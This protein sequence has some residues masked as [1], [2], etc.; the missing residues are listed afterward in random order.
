MNDPAILEAV[1]NLQ[2]RNERTIRAMADVQNIVNEV[3][4]MQ[5]MFHEHIMKCHMQMTS[6]RALD[7]L[8][9]SLI[10]RMLD[11]TFE[12]LAQGK[13]FVMNYHHESMCYH[14]IGLA[15]KSFIGLFRKSHVKDLEFYL[16][17]RNSSGQQEC[18][19]YCW[20]RLIS[21]IPSDIATAPNTLLETQSLAD[22]L[23]ERKVRRDPRHG[24]ILPI[25]C[26]PAKQNP[27]NDAWD[28]WTL[29]IEPLNG[30]ID[31]YMEACWRIDN[32]S[33]N[34]E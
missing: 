7:D 32:D 16:S 4:I 8:D 18:R 25:G 9:M 2:R 3:G 13:D 5:A 23:Y 12:L 1:A 11:N 17:H 14:L 29:K 33:D 22:L 30:W 21:F 24:N 19:F 28:E 6:N 34:D 20:E 26:R 27:A 10:T 15:L 31:R